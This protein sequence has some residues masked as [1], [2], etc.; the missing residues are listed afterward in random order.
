M[1]RKKKYLDT[2]SNEK[3]RPKMTNDLIHKF[4]SVPC[5]RI[6]GSHFIMRYHTILRVE[7]K[8]S[9]CFSSFRVVKRKLRKE[10]LPDCSSMTF[11]PQRCDRIIS[12]NMELNY[13]PVSV[14]KFLIALVIVFMMNKLNKANQHNLGN[15]YCWEVEWEIFQ[16]YYNLTIDLK[17]LAVP[18]PV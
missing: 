14:L 2:E 16:P 12:G 3:K 8:Y 10:M 15:N 13:T 4:P 11:R 18:C 5:G 17:E 6:R 1:Q 7:V 9:L